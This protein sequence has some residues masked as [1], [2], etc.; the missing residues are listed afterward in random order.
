MKPNRFLRCAVMTGLAVLLLNPSLSV[1]GAPATMNSVQVTIK[2]WVLPTADSHPHDPLAMADGSIWYTGQ[3]ADVLGRLD[4][5]IG[6]IR[7]FPVPKHSGPHGLVADQDGDIW[8]TANFA[9]YIGK[10]DPKTGKV[11]RYALP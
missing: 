5:S 10:L 6:K 2:E 8:F 1:A 7:E 11:T 4:P 3:L 9:G